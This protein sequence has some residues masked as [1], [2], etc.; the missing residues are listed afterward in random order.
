MRKCLW[1]H[2]MDIN[3]HRSQARSLYP[4]RKGIFRD[5]WHQSYSL[6]PTPC[7][8]SSPPPSRAAGHITSKDGHTSSTTVCFSPSLWE[9]E[10]GGRIDKSEHFCHEKNLRGQWKAILVIP[11]A[12]YLWKGKIWPNLQNLLPL[13]STLY[14]SPSST[15]LCMN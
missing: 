1:G 15:S 11:Q 14:F 5:L 13:E 3:L 10:V 4:S 8:C 2:R 9:S 6:S 7:R 12:V